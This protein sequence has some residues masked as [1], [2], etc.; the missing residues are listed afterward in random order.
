M[1]QPPMEGGDQLP[2][3]PHEAG[4][5]SHPILSLQGLVCSKGAAH[6]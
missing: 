5:T 4:A 1:T 2:V 3:L 6:H